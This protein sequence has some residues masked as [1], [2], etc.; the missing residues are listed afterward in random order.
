MTLGEQAATKKNLKI[1]IVEINKIEGGV[2]VFAR[3]WKNE[4]QIGFG[5]DGSVDI[6][7]FR[8][9]NPPVLVPDKNGTVI[10]AFV[11]EVTLKP[12]ISTYRED[13]QTA[14]LQSLEH[15]IAIMKN[16]HIGS[17]I[18]A[19]KKGNTTSTFYSDTG[20]DGWVGRQGVNETLST[21]RGGAGTNTQQNAESGA[22]ILFAS[23]TSNQYANMR[24]GVF[25]FD[26]SAIPDGDTITSATFSIVVSS[27][28]TSALG[29][30]D[31]CLVA[32]TPASNTSLSA[33][34]YTQ[35]GST[36]LA[37]RKSWAS[38]VK[39]STTYTDFALNAS[40]LANL[41]KTGYS[42]FGVRS[43]WDLDNSTTGLSWSSGAG[44]SLT[45]FWADEIGTT[46]DPKLVVEHSAAGGSNSDFL[47]FM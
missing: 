33:S 47:M 35:T 25:P 3:A 45:V 18:I 43:S 38:I 37:T 2:E 20:G 14:L 24:R 23:S 12:R 1:E 5:I 4:E 29:T 9:F 28:S 42:V 17:S 31:T 41:S 22:A 8:I 30:F 46:K 10:V 39:D 40:G 36:E 32:A 15:I 26:T 7:R 6:E 21:I 44:T 19:N 27:A 11:D 34:D 13:P 16:V